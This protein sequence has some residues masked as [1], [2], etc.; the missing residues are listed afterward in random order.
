MAEISRRSGGRRR[1]VRARLGAREKV[2][3]CAVATRRR[4]TS[5][6]PVTLGLAATAAPHFMSARVAFFTRCASATVI[7]SAKRG[8]SSETDTTG[9]R[10]ARLTGRSASPGRPHRIVA[11]G[12]I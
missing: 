8:R 2:I 10:G 6:A 7:A 12:D 5:S 11:D 3:P 1:T 9:A 4:T